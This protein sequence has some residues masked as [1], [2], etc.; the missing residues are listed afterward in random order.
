MLAVTYYSICLHLPITSLVNGLPYP[1]HILLWSYHRYFYIFDTTFPIFDMSSH[2]FY[3]WPLYNFNRPLKSSYS[4]DTY[5]WSSGS[6]YTSDS[7]P[8]YNLG[9]SCLLLN[10]W[11]VSK[12]II[13]NALLLWGW[14]VI[15]QYVDVRPSHNDFPDTPKK[16]PLQWLS[17]KVGK[18]RRCDTVLNTKLLLFHAIL[19]KIYLV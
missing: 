17:E 5:F 19:N 2:S 18:H 3:V 9:V 4:F 6:V 10:L 8:S 13:F 16:W 1:R 7:T 14:D 12:D 15:L 11:L